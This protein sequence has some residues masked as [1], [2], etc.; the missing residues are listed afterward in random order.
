MGK[1]SKEKEE[2]EKHILKVFYFKLG[3]VCSRLNL[4]FMTVK[5]KLTEKR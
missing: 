3:A 5:K 1:K 4:F 2:K